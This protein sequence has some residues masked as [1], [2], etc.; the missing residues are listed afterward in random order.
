MI[1]VIVILLYCYYLPSKEFFLLDLSFNKLVRMF[2][3]P[4]FCPKIVAIDI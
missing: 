2:E 4:L 1:I 3:L